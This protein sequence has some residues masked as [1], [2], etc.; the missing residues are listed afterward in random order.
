MGFESPGPI[1][2]GLARERL[3]AGIRCGIVEMNFA[4]PAPLGSRV[5]L[6]AAVLEAFECLG[7]LAHH[8]WAQS[9]FSFLILRGIYV[10][11][12]TEKPLFLVF[13]T[14]LSPNPKVLHSHSRMRASADGLLAAFSG[15]EERR[16]LLLEPFPSPVRPD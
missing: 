4:V 10:M 12:H 9:L 3:S 14:V 1:H 16:W 11:E 5:E 7:Q 2:P 8:G 15:K 6:P 13:Q